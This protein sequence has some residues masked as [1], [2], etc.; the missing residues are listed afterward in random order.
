MRFKLARSAPARGFHD[1]S[2]GPFQDQT[3]FDPSGR[4]VAFLCGGVCVLDLTT[5]QT[6]VAL[7]SVPSDLIA[8]NRVGQLVIP[9]IADGSV[10]TYD[11]HGE[12]QGVVQ[13]AGDSAS[14][15]A[16][17]S[18]VVVWFM[19]QQRPV[20]LVGQGSQRSLPVPGPVQAPNPQLSPDGTGLVV[21]CAGEGAQ[22]ALLLTP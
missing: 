18:I 21:V 3:L 14:A 5:G 22:E 13:D 9:S 8:W 11:V 15:S 10:T 1:R 4:S 20:V 2:S 17:G 6:T 12:R 16:D 19:S 7:P